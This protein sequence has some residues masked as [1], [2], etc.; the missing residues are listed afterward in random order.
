MPF[1]NF[2]D[3]KILSTRSDNPDSAARWTKDR[4]LVDRRI[5]RWKAKHDWYDDDA[6]RFALSRAY[7]EDDR[8]TDAAW[9]VRSV[10]Q[11]GL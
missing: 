10:W 4:G 11:F 1:K 6:E 7:Y 8:D 2:G 9:E 3:I 5:R